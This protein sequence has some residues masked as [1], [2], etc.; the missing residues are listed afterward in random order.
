MGMRH[1]KERQ[2]NWS[3]AVTQVATFELFGIW[4]TSSVVCLGRQGTRSI[5]LGRAISGEA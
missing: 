4:L 3:S 2:C 1:H 5:S